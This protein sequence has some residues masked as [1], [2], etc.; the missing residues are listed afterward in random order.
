ML[1]PGGSAVARGRVVSLY[2]EKCLWLYGG[3]RQCSNRLHREPYGG[4]DCCWLDLCCGPRLRSCSHRT[5][6]EVQT[7]ASYYEWGKPQ[8]SEES[9]SSCSCPCAMS[10]VR[11]AVRSF[12]ALS[13]LVFSHVQAVWDLGGD[14]STLNYYTTFIVSLVACSRGCS[15]FN[16]LQ[17]ILTDWGGIKLINSH[18]DAENDGLIWLCSF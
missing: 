15:L 16:I 2:T 8:R 14:M 9:A 10:L 13:R 7:L 6:G 4:V 1:W 17:L 11:S 12:C 3:W 5:T 18:A